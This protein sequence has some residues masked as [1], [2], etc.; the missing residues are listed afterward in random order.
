[1][2]LETPELF[3]SCWR[4]VLQQ[5]DEATGMSGDGALGKALPPYRFWR[6]PLGSPLSKAVGES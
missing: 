6:L 1:M 5:Q 2:Q 3:P 4:L